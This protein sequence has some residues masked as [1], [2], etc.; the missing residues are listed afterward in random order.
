ME[1]EQ[2]AGSLADPKTDL[3]RA[4]DGSAN[5]ITASLC[6]LT[7]HQPAQVCNAV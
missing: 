1:W 3:A 4:I 2:I 7:K 6:T 5:V